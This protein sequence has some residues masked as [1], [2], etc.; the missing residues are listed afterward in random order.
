MGTKSVIALHLTMHVVVI[1]VAISAWLF[2][3]ASLFLHK[4][5]RVLLVLLCFTQYGSFLSIGVSRLFAIA[6]CLPLAVAY[7]SLIDGTS[8]TMILLI[9]G[10]CQAILLTALL[11][12]QCKGER[13]TNL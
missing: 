6:A 1:L 2:P 8:N 12:L 4:T 7:A 13:A 11:L 5:V 9:V 10:V 3:G